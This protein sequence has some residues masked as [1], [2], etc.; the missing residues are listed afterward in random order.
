VTSTPRSF[1]TAGR[2]FYQLKQKHSTAKLIA[3]SPLIIILRGEIKYI[4]I[5]WPR[6]HRNSFR[7]E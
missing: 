1:K 2:Q 6:K 3:P 5:R 4:I 7:Y